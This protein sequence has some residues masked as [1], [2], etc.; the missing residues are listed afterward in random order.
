MRTPV[1]FILLHLAC[2]ARRPKTWRFHTAGVFRELKL[3]EPQLGRL[4]ALLAGI[5]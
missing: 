4:V 1:K 2:T 3:L 5:F